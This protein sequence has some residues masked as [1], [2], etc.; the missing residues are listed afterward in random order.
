MGWLNKNAVS[1]SGIKKSYFTG[2][3]VECKLNVPSTINVNDI[4][5]SLLKIERIKVITDRIQSNDGFMNYHNL[6]D[7]EKD[8]ETLGHTVCDNSNIIQLRIPYDAVNSSVSGL[9]ENGYFNDVRYAIIVRCY[10]NE[11]LFEKYVYFNVY[12]SIP[13]P[14]SHGILFPEMD[15]G[16]KTTI[17][18]KSDSSSFLP[19]ETIN[20]DVAIVNK[21]SIPIFKLNVIYHQLENLKRGMAYSVKKVSTV[22]WNKLKVIRGKNTTEEADLV[23][24]RDVLSNNGHVNRIR[25]KLSNKLPGRVRKLGK[26]KCSKLEFQVIFCNGYSYRSVATIFEY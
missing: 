13:F 25:F 26:V 6:Y 12:N 21:T 20:C 24:M 10:M 17:M 7:I 14:F 22:H 1:I 18:V 19:G 9:Y 4:S 16:K 3:L 2:E 11:S 5:I 15:F 23:V 8:E